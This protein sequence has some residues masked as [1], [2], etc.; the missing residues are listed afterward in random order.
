MERSQVIGFL[1]LFAL[2][3]GYMFYISPS[4][5]ELEKQRKIQ[6]SLRLVEQHRRDSAILADQSIQ[7]TITNI[8]NDTLKKD[9]LADTTSTNIAKV[10]EAY[11]FFQKSYTSED[12]IILISND[13]ADISFS[14]KGAV[15]HSVEL[16]NFKDYKNN[17]VQLLDTNN[18]EFSFVFRAF[19]RFLE[20]KNLFFEPHI[21][22]I[23]DTTFV[24]FLANAIDTATN[25]ILGGVKIEYAIPKD[26]YMLD[27]K[28]SF[29][30]PANI[31][32]LPLDI[33]T[34]TWA[35]SMIQQEKDKKIE[36]TN[37]TI[38]YMDG[39]DKVTH[40]KA[41]DQQET[42]NFRVKWIGLKQQFFTHTLINADD[43]FS[44]AQLETKSFNPDD[45]T[46]YLRHLSVGM[47]IEH[48]S[49]KP[50]H[51]KIFTGPLKYNILRDYKLRLE[52]EIP[53][54]WGFAPIAWVNRF[55][56]IPVFNWLEKYG[57]NY[58]II[59]LI[60]TILLKIILL[61]FTYQTYMSSA[62][63][64]ALKPEITKI[65]E[66]YPKP[67]DA[68]KKQQETMQ[69][70]KKSKINPAGGCWP[71]LLQFPILIA[72]FRFFPSAI[73]LRHQAFLWAHDLS[74]SDSILNLGV[75]IPLYG[76][77][78]SLFAL[79]MAISTLLYTYINNKLTPTDNTM[80]G[81][82]LMLYGMPILFLGIFNNYSA[83][84]SYYYFLF[85]VISILQTYTFRLF[86]NE[87][88]IRA[89]LIENWKKPVKKS[90]WQQRMEA[91]AKQQQA[92]AR[93]R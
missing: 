51:F 38:C 22:K 88:K 44:A 58:G 5:E 74:A 43:Y 78:V 20:T 39:D 68:L 62:K 79:L 27:Y 36:T 54:G 70:Y 14:C 17:P 61:P 46:R 65:N 83:A 75:N 81:M 90:S 34:F 57:L 1:L 35:N 4:T 47:T 28:L 87:E 60:L 48:S 86:V 21:K 30:N 80:P 56:V 7:D 10:P 67:E 72:M 59:I 23:G 6:D 32:V 52:R 73:E 63:M 85:N 93:K 26:E 84:L 42:L 49:D 64:R 25:E 13:V 89:K 91:L 19:D 18:Y 3:V 45:Y 55:L 11:K 24:T 40:L 41:K 15:L 8:I 12:S 92:N 50:I 31:G 2:L 37:T 9:Q 82:K 29:V 16:K 76:D 33:L 71:V 66:K 53:L 77:H 69:L